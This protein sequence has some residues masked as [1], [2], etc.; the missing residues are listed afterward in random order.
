M[1][2]TSFCSSHIW[3]SVNKHIC[4]FL[5]A[6][7][8]NSFIYFWCYDPLTIPVP[9][10]CISLDSWTMT[11]CW[12]AAE[13][14]IFRSNPH[15]FHKMYKEC[16][17]S[18]SILCFLCQ[19]G[20]YLK[21]AGDIFSAQKGV[22]GFV[23]KCFHHCVP[24]LANLA[25]AGAAGWLAGTELAG[26][27]AGLVGPAEPVVVAAVRPAGLSARQYGSPPLPWT[28]KACS[29]IAVETNGGSTKTC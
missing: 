21:A 25:V 15:I 10:M 19:F 2:S 6:S 20:K 5:Y 9:P 11:C 24:L 1:S 16:T 26:S 8:N 3:I 14:N 18:V 23:Q 17:R 22:H 29:P 12:G 4:Y 28:A 7:L 13:T 27:P